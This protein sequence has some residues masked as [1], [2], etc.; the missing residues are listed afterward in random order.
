MHINNVGTRVALFALDLEDGEKRGTM[1]SGVKSHE[2]A[3]PL[4]KVHFPEGEMEKRKF[5]LSSRYNLHYV[6]A[7]DTRERVA[8]FISKA[9]LKFLVLLR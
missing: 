3:S 4:P 2:P 7:G 8:P 9:I 1:V 5:D 6:G